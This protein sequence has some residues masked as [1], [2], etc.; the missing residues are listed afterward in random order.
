MTS[1]SRSKQRPATEKSAAQRAARKRPPKAPATGKPSTRKTQ[2]PVIADSAAAA[3]GAPA[4]PGA[5]AS[6]KRAAPRSLSSGLSAEY[7]RQ[8]MENDPPAVD[9][10]PPMDIEPQPRGTACFLSPRNKAPHAVDCQCGMCDD[11]GRPTSHSC[12]AGHGAPLEAPRPTDEQ[13]LVRQRG[14]RIGRAGTPTGQ[15][16]AYVP[17]KIYTD[18][19]S[20]ID[21]WTPLQS[22]C[23]T[24]IDALGRMRTDAIVRRRPVSEED[25]RELYELQRQTDQLIAMLQEAATQ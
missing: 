4:L 6:P 18:P 23:E 13:E 15:A 19:N 9:R 25:L 1:P 3:E 24:A 17:Q 16:P 20:L 22:A 8:I 7:Q 10:Q 2:D 12:C 14:C 21:P 11:S 5:D